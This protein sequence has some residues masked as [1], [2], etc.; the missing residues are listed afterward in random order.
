MACLLL[1]ASAPV[2]HA[3]GSEEPTTTDSPN[4]SEDP[5]Q[6]ESD[7][8]IYLDTTSDPPVYRVKEHCTG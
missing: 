3:D 7:P 2:V 8:C 4:G 1:L 6:T 5:P